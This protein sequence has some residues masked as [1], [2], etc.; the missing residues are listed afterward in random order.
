MKNL[1]SYE[2]RQIWLDFF[3]EKGHDIIESAPLIPNNDP[4][5]LW[6]NAGVTPLK[7]YFD[8]SDIPNNKRM[9]NAQKCI[10]TND[11]ENVGKTARHHTFFEMLGNFSIGDY[12]REEALEFAIEILT[13]PKW[14]G[15]DLDRLYFTVYPDDTDTIDKWISLGVN[16]SHII[17]LEGN[18]WEIGEGPCGPDTEIFYD[19]G[20]KY[21]PDGLGIKM[22]VEDMSNE[23]YIEIWN[24]VFSQYNAKNGVPRDKYKELPS[25][26]I[27]TGMGLERMAC[28]IQGV[29]TNYETDLFMPII[30]EVE[31]LVNRKYDGEMAYKVIADHTRTV[32]FSL[33]DGATFSNEGRGYVLRR[34]LR[35]A[36][37]FG[38]KLGM[39]EPFLYKLVSVVVDNMKNA[40]PYLITKI[41]LVTKL[42]KMEEEKFLMTLESGEKKLLDYIK[43]SDN[44]LI[45][46]EVA[47]LLYDTFGFPFELTSEVA[48]EHGCEVDEVGFNELLQLQR[49]RAREARR[50]NDS[51]NTQNEDMLKFKEEDIFIGYTELESL[52]HVI[53]V[54][55]DGKKVSSGDGELLLVFDKTPF[56]AESGGQV[57]DIG[58]LSIDNKNF[59]VTNTI[60]L[61][62]A[63][64]GSIVNM[65]SD[66]ISVG[67]KVL[68]SVDEKFRSDVM[69]N[70][71]ATH[72]LNEALRKVIGQH[73]V[74]QGSFV[75]NSF[76]RFDF[77]NF[78]PLTNEELL[79]IE[80]LVNKEIK[81]GNVVDIKEMPITEA[82]KLNVQAVFGE[83][84]GDV[85]R[86]IDMDFSKELCG[87]TH[88][89]NTKDIEKFAILSIETKGSGI[90]RIEASTSDNIIE[91]MGHTLENINKEISNTKEKIN[92]LIIDANKNDIKLE[93]NDLELSDLVE[94]YQSIINRREELEILRQDSKELEKTLNK[95][96]LEKNSMDIS[97]YLKE[98][99]EIN[100]NK[101]LIIKE[102][103]VN[104]DAA[105]DLLDR[106]SDHLKDSLI[107]IAIV[108]DKVVFL[109]KNKLNQLHAG[110][111][112]KLAAVSTNGNGGGRSDFAQA[113]GKDITKVEFALGEV[114][115]EV[116]SKL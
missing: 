54:F 68:L 104:I 91:E 53:G 113:G 11:I 83:K 84:Y 12:F 7:K 92:D 105:K 13:S 96:I 90:Y 22:L 74:Q 36:V 20:K 100:G 40:Y 116:K 57:G 37:R 99:I 79:K 88:V 5:L 3:K 44:K 10:R 58:S 60:K 52:S 2:I 64:H 110:N 33:S 103:N 63:Q 102:E 115:K 111:L 70:H 9:A 76:L 39:N 114:L 67:D 24:I 46:K 89:H 62:N 4:T 18:F 45:D 69:K 73:V 98:V 66:T 59:A 71:S 47:F 41:E 80:D 21:D 6:I 28:V 14:Y 42:V 50:N 55:K 108:S 75:G 56:Y 106:L 82:K 93:Y 32:V 16:P 38:K 49:K 61:P 95:L 97:S 65:N 29:D 19:R 48:S 78:S 15:F 43:A 30:N 72:L 23:R 8:G 87:G 17:K 27:D 77:N 31:K 107:F 86:V 81:N 85:V 1:K 94:S 34:L 109:C 35:R 26:N 51:M 25:K 101:I 112:V